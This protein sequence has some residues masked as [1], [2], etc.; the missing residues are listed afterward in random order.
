MIG[1]GR[2]VT[3]HVTFGYLTDVYV[4]SAHQGRGLARWM[5]GCVGEM[6]DGW[7]E[8]RRCLLLTRDAAAVRLYRDTI[9][10]RD[11][12]ETSTSKLFIC[13]RPGTTVK[14][15]VGEEGINGTGKGEA[16]GEGTNA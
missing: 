8:L 5:M 4:L 3:D 11:V 16:G 15:L 12:R 1:F 6:L 10:A 7:P 14:V 13:E 9:G 2:L